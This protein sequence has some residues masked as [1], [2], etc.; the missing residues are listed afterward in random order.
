M[1]KVLLALAA[2]PLV[3]VPAA[4]AHAERPDRDG[5]PDC[6]AP[7]VETTYHV[8]QLR[9]FVSLP[10]SGCAAREHSMFDLTATV[11]R[12]DNQGSHD[13]RRETASCGPFRSAAD[14]EPGDPPGT[15][16]CDLTLAFHHPKSEAAQYDIDLTY[17]GGDGERTISHVLFCRSDGDQASC[18]RSGPSAERDAEQ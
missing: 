9:V 14:A 4:S 11:T 7:T 1:R 3:V 17:P 12:M 5:K 10:A 15:Y 16:S 13:V 18:E 6:P 8:D 2:V